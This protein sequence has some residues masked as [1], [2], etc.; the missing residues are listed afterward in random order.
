MVFF[1]RLLLRPNPFALLSTPYL[2]ASNIRTLSTFPVHQQNVLFANQVII[3][4]KES[5]FKGNSSLIAR[6]TTNS[7]I[8]VCCVPISSISPKIT[9]CARANPQESSIVL[10]TSPKTFVSTANPCFSYTTTSVWKSKTR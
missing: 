7:V 2:T 9:N 5:A 4:W 6:S 8:L 1:C 3:K 10:V